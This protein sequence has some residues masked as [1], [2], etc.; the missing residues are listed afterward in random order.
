MGGSQTSTP[1]DRLLWE[2]LTGKQRAC[3]DLL[4]ERKTSKEIA[5]RL[6][7]SKFTVDQRLRTARVVLGAASRDDTAL[8]YARLKRICDRVAY[9]PVDVPAAATIVPS[10]FA[11]GGPEAILDMRDSVGI[12]EAPAGPALPSG[13]FWRHD[14]ALLA[15]LLI[16]AA[17]LSTLIVFFAGSI[18]I[19]EVLTRLLAG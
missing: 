5:R 17:L 16:M 11:D 18:G 9:H 15:R 19:A 7:I 4:L 12:G 1:E 13:K 6:G 10:D 2:R 14:H 8:R 3:L